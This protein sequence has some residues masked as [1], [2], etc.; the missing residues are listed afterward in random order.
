MES[1][2][3]GQ[4][5]SVK[6]LN[7]D[8]FAVKSQKTCLIASPTLKHFKCSFLNLHAC[9]YIP[10]GMGKCLIRQLPPLKW[11]LQ[12]DLYEPFY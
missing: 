7:Y 12:T 1:S 11:D 2:K 10:A 8:K 4:K 3:Y 9:C 6:H 5:A